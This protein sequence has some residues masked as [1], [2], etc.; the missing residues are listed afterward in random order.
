M[1]IILSGPL[2]TGSMSVPDL[3]VAK[4]FDALGAECDEN[5]KKV[6]V[7]KLGNSDENCD[8]EKEDVVDKDRIV[9]E[10]RNEDD[11]HFELVELDGYWQ[12]TL[13][14]GGKK[15]PILGVPS[16][17]LGPSSIGIQ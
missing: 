17:N 1:R 4:E 5:S 8:E 14:S 2:I 10:T 6:V 11:E 15:R 3:D 13:G 12:E 9:R 7:G 16:I